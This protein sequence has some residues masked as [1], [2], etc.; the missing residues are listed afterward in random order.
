MGRIL[1]SILSISLML[2]GLFLTQVCREW[3]SFCPSSTEILQV[4]QLQLLQLLLTT[5][6]HLHLQS[7]SQQKSELQLDIMVPVFQREDRLRLFATDLAMAIANYTNNNN[8]YNHD[9][10]GTPHITTFRLLVTRYSS[11]ETRPT[12][13]FEFQSELSRL[14]Y[15]P[16]DNIVMIHAAAGQAFS[17]ARALNLLHDHAC[18]LD[19]CLATG[20]D[21]DME[22][23]HEFFQHA[24]EVVVLMREEAKQE[25]QQQ[26]EDPRL[27]HQNASLPTAYFPIVWSAY[28]PHS[29]QLVQSFL[30][31]QQQLDTTTN[32][33]LNNNVTQ[34]WDEFSE[35]A[36]HW[37]PYGTGMYVIRGAD[38]RLLRYNTS[39]VG[40]G[41]EDVDFYNKTVKLRRSIRRQETGLIHVWHVKTCTK[42]TDVI[43]AAKKRSCHA[44]VQ[45]DGSKLGRSFLSKERK[46]KKRQLSRDKVYKQ[47]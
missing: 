29:I 4:H 34:K 17:R 3:T 30:Q 43:T 40:W 9:K 23:R 14:S 39:F 10:G 46:R 8:K 28:N 35:H 37:R 2:Q 25:Q 22:I 42:G 33:Q 44:S 1:L 21:V 19:H 15:L 11:E 16:K 41:G 13:D 7:Q 31:Q 12:N 24:V 36:G 32:S 45:E 5:D 20:V 27:L 26:Q 6:P 38:A 47:G 18:H